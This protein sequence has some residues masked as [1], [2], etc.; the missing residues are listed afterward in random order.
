MACS[1]SEKPKKGTFYALGNKL[2]VNLKRLFV[3]E[4]Y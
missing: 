2:N 4:P 3:K 1:V